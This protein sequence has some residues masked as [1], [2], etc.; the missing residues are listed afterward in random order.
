MGKELNEVGTQFADFKELGDEALHGDVIVTK[1]FLPE[2]FES[3]Q[4]V[5]DACL[6][7][8]EMS[9]HYHGIFGNPGSFDLRE[10]QKTRVKHLRV[11]ETVALKHQEHSPIMIP[12][13]DYRIG[14][15]KEYDPFEKL[16][17]KVAD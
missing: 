13:G 7:Y 5:D 14:I 3:M 17:R 4:K 2:D 6:A 9:G 8:G 10:C 16:S 1:D 15:Q 11:V 12:P